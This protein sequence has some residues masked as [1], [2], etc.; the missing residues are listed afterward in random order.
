M[1]PLQRMLELGKPH[2]QSTVILGGR[3]QMVFR[4]VEGAFMPSGKGLSIRNRTDGQCQTAGG[5][6]QK[7]ERKTFSICHLPFVHFPMDCALYERAMTN[8]KLEMIYGKCFLPSAFCLLPSAFCRLPLPS[9][10][11]LLLLP[12]APAVC[13]LPSAFPCRLLYFPPA[14]RFSVK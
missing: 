1:F 11:C 2:V 5:R 10:S 14:G 9:A 3:R 4:L 12:S 8:E 6:R 7:A 13:L